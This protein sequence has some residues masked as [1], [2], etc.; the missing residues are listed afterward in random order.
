ML[1]TCATIISAKANALRPPASMLGSHHVV[2]KR[3]APFHAL[4]ALHHQGTMCGNLLATHCA[5]CKITFDELRLPVCPDS[6]ATVNIR[7]LGS[8]PGC[9]SSY[10]M[11]LF[12][13]KRW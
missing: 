2:L 7:A 4:S 8:F 13:S 12:I 11:D 1:R 6:P 10:L 9:P 5:L 3:K